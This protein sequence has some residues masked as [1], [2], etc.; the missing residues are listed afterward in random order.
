MPDR[1]VPAILWII[2][3]LLLLAMFMGMT[4][5]MARKK[6]GLTAGIASASSPKSVEPSRKLLP[7][8]NVKATVSGSLQRRATD[9]LSLQSAVLEILQQVG[10]EL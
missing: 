10:Y 6:I 9:K 3:V 5:W 4:V 1:S 2:V 7:E 8:R